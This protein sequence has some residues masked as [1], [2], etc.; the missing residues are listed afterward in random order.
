[1]TSAR[2]RRGKRCDPLPPP[3]HAAG[4]HPEQG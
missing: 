3:G 1:V 4:T 2:R